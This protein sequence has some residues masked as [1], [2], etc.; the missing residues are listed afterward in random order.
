MLHRRQHWQPP[1]VSILEIQWIIVFMQHWKLILNSK[2]WLVYS[3]LLELF[4]R[5]LKL[6]DCLIETVKGSLTSRQCIVLFN[7]VIFFSHDDCHTL[8]ILPSFK[9][10][11]SKVLFNVSTN[12]KSSYQWKEWQETLICKWFCCLKAVSA[13]HKHFSGTNFNPHIFF[14]PPHP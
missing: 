2:E 11:P 3:K 13:H 9:S 5:L 10:E 7:C 4:L 1:N 8:H 12:L 6:H 14:R